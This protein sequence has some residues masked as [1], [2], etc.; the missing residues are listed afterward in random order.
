MVQNA[1]GSTRSH[2]NWYFT[3]IKGN[4]SAAGNYRSNYGSLN[5][6]TP[7]YTDADR[8]LDFYANG[9][10]FRSDDVNTNESG[11]YYVFAAFAEHPFKIA[12][13]A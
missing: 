10:Q 7:Q 11:S 8:A 2:K 13:A 5:K 6:N 1:D 3:D 12:R 4:P 9:F